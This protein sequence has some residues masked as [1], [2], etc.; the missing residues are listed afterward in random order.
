MNVE[1]TATGSMTSPSCSHSW[2]GS[3]VVWLVV[4]CYLHG[5][6]KMSDAMGV[7]AFIVWQWH[8]TVHIEAQNK[9]ERPER[10]G[11]DYKIPCAK[12]HYRGM[13]VAKAKAKAK[14]NAKATGEA[15]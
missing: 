5:K 10:W 4:V 8:S 9:R 15:V 1:P 3:T 11:W 2:F 6:I 14:G 13:P 12:L 7:S